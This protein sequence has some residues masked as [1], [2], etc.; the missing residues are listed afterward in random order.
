MLR[1]TADAE[2]PAYLDLD[3]DVVLFQGRRVVG[4]RRMAMAGGVAAAALVLGVGSW[5]VLDQSAGR[6]AEEVPA[7]PTTSSALGVVTATLP[8]TPS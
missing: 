6:A 5:A 1:E 8:A 3:P 7:T 4:R 2:G